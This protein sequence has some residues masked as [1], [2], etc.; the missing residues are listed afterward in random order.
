MTCPGPPH[1]VNWNLLRSRRPGRRVVRTQPVG[2]DAAPHLRAARIGDPAVLAPPRRT[3]L[4]TQQPAS[5]LAVRLPPRTGR[6]RRRSGGTATSPTPASGSANGSPPPAPVW[7]AT[8]PPGRPPGPA[9]TPPPGRR[10]VRSPTA[11]RDFV[12]Y[13]AEQVA[14]RRKAKE[15]AFYAGPRADPLRHWG[16]ARL[17]VR[18]YVRKTQ[19]RRY[20]DRTCAP[21]SPG[22]S[23][24]TCTSSP[25]S[26]SASTMRETGLSRIDR[27]GRHP[28][29]GAAEQ[30][31]VDPVRS[32]SIRALPAYPCVARTRR[33]SA[34]SPS[35]VVTAQRRPHPSSGIG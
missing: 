25:K 12:D 1:P 35:C 26:S 17:V 18:N 9:K 30:R 15:D 27:A 2:R 20:A 28:T 10:H 3:G 24:S 23:R 14:D 11:T 19:R 13:V 7:I 6:V 8:G 4:G 21:P 32:T 34:G 5:A 22:A 33:G 31:A 29:P 16:G